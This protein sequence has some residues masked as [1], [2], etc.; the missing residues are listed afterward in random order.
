[1]NASQKN[2]G[3]TL[4]ELLVVI[5][6]IGV[7]SSVVL[8]SLKNVRMRANDTARVSDI[9]SIR[10]AME[11]YYNDNHQ[12]PRYGDPETGNYLKRLSGTLTPT[13]VSAIPL[14]LINDMTAYTWSGTDSYGLYIYTE[15]SNSYCMT[16]V[17][18][19]PAWW[20]FAPNCN[21]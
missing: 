14:I 1:M 20:N 8:A 9:R 21:F 4:I 13:Y 7:L 3:F 15:A 2:R 19:N 6:I 10:T 18:V 12:Y 17:N 5:A 16:G 11:M